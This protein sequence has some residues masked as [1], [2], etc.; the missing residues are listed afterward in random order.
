MANVEFDMRLQSGDAACAD[1]PRGETLRLLEQVAAKV[2]G[3][4]DCGVLYDTNGRTVGRFSLT[5]E[6]PEIHCP[7]CGEEPTGQNGAGEW[8]CSHCGNAWGV[9]Q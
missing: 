9:D 4:S 1:D 5:I 8:L 3:G 7:D 2:R 6:T